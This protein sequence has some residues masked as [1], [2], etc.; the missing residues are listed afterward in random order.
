MSLQ[1]ANDNEQFMQPVIANTFPT[2]LYN[3]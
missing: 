2:L 3:K 1:P